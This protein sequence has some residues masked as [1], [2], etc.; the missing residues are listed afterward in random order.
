[1]C[2]YLAFEESP[3]Q[4]IRNMK[5]IGI[6]LQPWVDKGLLKF[7]ATRPTLYGL[8]MHL[9]NIYDLVNEFQ[10][11]LVVFDPISNLIT[12]GTQEEVKSM[13]TRLLDFLKNKMI[14]SMSTSLTTMS[15]MD[16]EVGV[17][18]LMDSWID[19]KAN[20][21]DGERNRTID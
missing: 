5:S 10:P 15:Q 1:K 11:D 2:L 19:L 6:N 20:E 12:A 8:E 9:I 13:L 18:S 16:T 14:T 4:I 21:K 17:S 3:K 7:H